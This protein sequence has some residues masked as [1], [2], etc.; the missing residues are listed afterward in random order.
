MTPPRSSSGVVI[1]RPMH[2]RGGERR[3][4]IVGA[5]TRGGDD[6]VGF[7]QHALRVVANQRQQWRDIVD[8]RDPL[9]EGVDIILYLL[10]ERSFISGARRLKR[11]ASST[12]LFSSS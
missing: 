2:P 6:L 5:R 7:G 3:A 9:R 8:A 4:G 1:K 12:N 10:G 11:F